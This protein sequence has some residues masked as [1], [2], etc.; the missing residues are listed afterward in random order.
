M[1]EKINHST[2]K[3]T[4]SK[5]GGSN[6]TKQNKSHELRP[7][8]R[9]MIIWRMLRIGK[10]KTCTA[11]LYVE[12]VNCSYDTS[13][14]FEDWLVQLWVC[15]RNSSTQVVKWETPIRWLVA[16]RHVVRNKL[17]T[18]DV[19]SCC[20]TQLLIIKISEITN[21]LFV[22]CLYFERY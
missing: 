13:W 12:R 4:W 18:S 17:S 11:T 16:I 1:K 19:S 9:L 14:V 22:W 10:R 20:I 15:R 3:E 2:K 7:H 6:A 5:K 8:I 21:S